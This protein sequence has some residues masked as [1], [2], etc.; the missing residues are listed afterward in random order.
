M[1]IQF[2]K[3]TGVPKGRYDGFGD[4]VRVVNGPAPGIM[5]LSK[6]PWADPYAQPPTDAE[7]VTS[8]P[9]PIPT[10][11]TTAI[12]PEAQNIVAPSSEDIAQTYQVL[13]NEAAQ[14]PTGALLWA[15]GAFYAYCALSSK[16]PTWARI[17][18]GLLG[19]NLVLKNFKVTPKS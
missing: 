15:Q 4:E 1:A 9:A 17:L 2:T 11:A 8:T 14:V 19:A 5:T 18:A 13:Q 7:I 6:D 3:E 10:S 16:L 12:V